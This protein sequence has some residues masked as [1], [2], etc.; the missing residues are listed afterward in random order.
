MHL[1][2]VDLPLAPLEWYYSSMNRFIRRPLG[3]V[4]HL[5]LRLIEGRDTDYHQGENARLKAENR[6]L[7]V[8]IDE[9]RAEVR[10]GET[11]VK[12][13]GTALERNRTQMIKDIA[14]H[15]REANVEPTPARRG[16]Q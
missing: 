15:Q 11:E 10:V 16:R 4:C 3:Y 2:R 7:R 5:I 13:L 6:E 9:L 14:V 1:S 12:L 8:T